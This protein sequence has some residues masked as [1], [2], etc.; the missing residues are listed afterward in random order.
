MMMQEDMKTMDNKVIKALGPNDS[1]Y[2]KRF[3]DLM[4]AHHEG[5]L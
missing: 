3:I 4:I 1:M 2:D 5:E